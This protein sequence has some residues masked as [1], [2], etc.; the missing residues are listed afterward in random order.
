MFSSTSIHN[1]V[2]PGESHLV[3][4]KEIDVLL[5]PYDRSANVTVLDHVSIAKLQ[6]AWVHPSVSLSEIWSGLGP[7]DVAQQLPQ[8][9]V[10]IAAKGHVVTGS[11]AMEAQHHDLTHPAEF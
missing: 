4:T 2:I 9:F 6:S 5:L 7:T 10:H 3:C 11:V 1:E 8:R